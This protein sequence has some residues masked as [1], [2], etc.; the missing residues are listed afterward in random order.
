MIRVSGADQRE[1]ENTIPSCFMEEWEEEKEKVEEKKKQG[2]K[3]KT[4]T[5]RKKET[6]NHFRSHSSFMRDILD[7]CPLFRLQHASFLHFLDNPIINL[8][9]C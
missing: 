9:G 8:Q 7:A 4:G 1:R 5:K 6:E 3:A 2:K